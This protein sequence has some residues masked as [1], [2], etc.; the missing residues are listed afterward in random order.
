MSA[1]KC[2]HSFLTLGGSTHVTS[3]QMGDK[4]WDIHEINETWN[5][6]KFSYQI[7]QCYQIHV[8]VSPEILRE[9][10]GMDCLQN[11]YIYIYIFAPHVRLRFAKCGWIVMGH[12]PKKYH[13][14]FGERSC[15]IGTTNPCLRVRVDTCCFFAFATWYVS[16]TLTCIQPPKFN[17]RI[18]FHSPRKRRS[19]FISSSPSWSA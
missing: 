11:V 1:W 19:H 5:S 8:K 16:R 3:A 14:T 9:D 10:I 7:H 12:E 18:G 13:V 6:F 15:D 2:R 17:D 4:R